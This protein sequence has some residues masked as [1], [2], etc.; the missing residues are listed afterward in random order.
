MQIFEYPYVIITILAMFFIVM[1]L[2]GLYFTIKSVKTAKGTLQKDFCSMGKIENDFEKRGHTGKNRCVVYISLSLDSMKRLYAESKAIR[3]FEQ[4]KKILLNHFSLDI[5]GEIS[6]YDEENFVAINA[7]E[8]A[9]IAKRIDKSCEE[10][11]EVF[12]KHS[13][14]N[15]V[16]INFGYHLTSSTDVSFKTALLRAKQACSMAED[17]KK[18]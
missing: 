14:V 17:K 3:M 10:I 8:S 9:E 5:D 7:L 18:H 12:I 2:I 4:I 13:A 16:R 15:V 1:G 11:N 6:V